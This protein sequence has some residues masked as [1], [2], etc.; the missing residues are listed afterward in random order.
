MKRA[1]ARFL[2]SLALR[3]PQTLAALKTDMRQ[4]L[5][6]QLRIKPEI[7]EEHRASGDPR[8]IVAWIEDRFPS[9]FLNGSGTLVLPLFI[10]ELSKPLHAMCWFICDLGDAATSLLTSDRPLF[11]QHGFGDPRC[12]VALPLSPRLL[13]VAANTRESIQTFAQRQP[14]TIVGL[15]NERLVTQAVA[16]VYGNTKEHRPMVE[17][18]LRPK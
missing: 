15:I 4:Q 3:N 12:I 10:E 2:M 6:A 5:I 18:Y 7:Q 9:S 16:H 13:F 11:G 1:W 14:E 17:K 8:D